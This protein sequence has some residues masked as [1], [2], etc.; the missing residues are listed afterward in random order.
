MITNFQYAVRGLYGVA[1]PILQSAII[2]ANGLT[3]ALTYNKP[4]DETSTSATTDF[5]LVGTSST[6]NGIGVS[7]SVVTLTVDIK[8][9]ISETVTIDYTAGVDPIRSIAKN[10]AADLVSQAVV[11]NSLVSSGAEDL[12][13]YTEVDPES[14]LAVIPTKVTVVDIHPEHTIT[15]LYY[16]FGVNHFK[17]DFEMRFALKV[18]TIWTDHA[19]QGI[20]GVSNS[21]GLSVEGPN[22][23]INYDYTDAGSGANYIIGVGGGDHVAHSNQNHFLVGTIYYCKIERIYV[24]GAEDNIFQMTVYTDSNIQLERSNF[25]VVV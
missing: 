2:S 9:F 10:N 16:D 3:I 6:I 4:L 5:S 8:I 20:I 24:G 25:M 7:G 19:L 12:S 17:K 13:T 14:N 11:N 21:L 15:Y 18:N 22:I 1:P 23:Q